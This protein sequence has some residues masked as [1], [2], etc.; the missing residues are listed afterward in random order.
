VGR[1][2]REENDMVTPHVLYP[3][4]V[5]MII[6]AEAISWNRFYSFLMFNT[7]L[8]LAWST[9]YAAQA[10][11]ADAWTVLATMTILGAVSGIAM[12]GLSIRG[13]RFLDEYVNLAEKIEADDK[14]WSEELKPYKPLT[15]TKECIKTF[16][17]GW[18]GSGHLLTWG[19]FAFAAFYV[20]LFHLSI[21]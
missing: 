21:R 12:V 14:C 15:L 18:A 4:L 3:S 7:I 13:R 9:I 5:Q 2:T 19:S 10:C 20:F 17:H 16:P 6:H 11:P 8:I 1:V